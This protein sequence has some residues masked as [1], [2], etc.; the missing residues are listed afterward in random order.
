VGEA[1]RRG[2]MDG[3]GLCDSVVGFV[4]ERFSNDM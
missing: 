3:H 2:M 1:Q 4:V